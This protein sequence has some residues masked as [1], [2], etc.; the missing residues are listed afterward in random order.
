MSIILVSC[1]HVLNYGKFCH[2]HCFFM[3]TIDLKDLIF[4]DIY[5]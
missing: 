4:V 5:S 1:F 2:V 3:Y